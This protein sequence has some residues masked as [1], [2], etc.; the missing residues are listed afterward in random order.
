MIRS[1][2]DLAA[3]NR[4]YTHMIDT[5][6]RLLAKPTNLEWA[7]AEL[8]EARLELLSAQTAVDHA[9]S[10]VTYNQTRIARLEEYLFGD[11][12]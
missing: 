8:T 9:H 7:A 2:S 6:K 5:L 11:A 3:V 12:K 10:V 1:G 4:G